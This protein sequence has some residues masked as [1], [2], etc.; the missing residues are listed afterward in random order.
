MVRVR[1]WESR[2]LASAADAGLW[3]RL[4][5]SHAAAG[6]AGSACRWR[7]VGDRVLRRG[8]HWALMA[9]VE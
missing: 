4:A 1:L 9:G 7:E 3:V 8:P 6:H 2:G 5:A